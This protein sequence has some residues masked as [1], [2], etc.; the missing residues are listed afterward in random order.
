MS[1]FVAIVDA[2]PLSVDTKEDLEIICK[3]IGKNNKIS[4][5]D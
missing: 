2:H 5:H 4:D 1:I 3:I